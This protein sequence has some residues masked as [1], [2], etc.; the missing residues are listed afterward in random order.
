VELLYAP[1][2]IRRPQPAPDADGSWVA[3]TGA[4]TVSLNRNGATASA[5]IQASVKSLRDRRLVIQTVYRLDSGKVVYTMPGPY[6]VPS[7]PT[8]L[9]RAGVESQATGPIATFAVLGPLIDLHKQPVNDCQ[10]QRDAKSL[11]IEV[12]AG[13]RMLSNE[14]DVHNAPMTLADVDGDF[15]AQVR[16]AGGMVPGTD[17]PRFKGK[18]V[19]PGTYQGAG[20]LLWQD[21]KNDILVER[22]V[23]TKRGQIV[24]TSKVLVD[25]IK[26]GKS[27]AA[28]PINTVD[29][30]LY[31]RL[32]RID[33]ALAFLFGTDGKRWI[34][35]K[36]L[37]VTFPAKVQVGLVACNMSKQPLTAKFEGFVLV[38]EKKDL[39]DPMKP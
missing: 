30:P 22:S 19:L 34:T 27:I 38:T 11:T 2:S 32:Q 21:A 20:V 31:L 25:I 6:Q 18:N 14:L 37:A 8:P 24:L 39:T 15:V 4:E 36:K 16:V 35:S 28:F 23:S 1:D 3:L 13:V 17:P 26:G 5:T 29:G 33:G 9:A 7:R 10:L 12:P